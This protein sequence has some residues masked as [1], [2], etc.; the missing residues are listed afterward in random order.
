MVQKSETIDGF[1][2]Q[3]DV[4]QSGLALERLIFQNCHG[5]HLLDVKE[6]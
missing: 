5:K 3:G 4:C 2:L 1:C 6:R